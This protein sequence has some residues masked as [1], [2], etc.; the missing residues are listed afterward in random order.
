MPHTITLSNSGAVVPTTGAPDYGG[1][2]TDFALL[3]LALGTI[4]AALPGA[5]AVPV[6][7]ADTGAANAYAITYSPAPTVAAGSRFLFKALHTNTGAS[8]L[9]V[10][11]AATVPITDSVNAA[12]IG[13]EILAGQLCL[14]VYD[15]TQYQLIGSYNT[16]AIAAAI[17]NS[18]YEYAADTGAVN[19]YAVALTPSPAALV[20]GLS[21]QFKVKTLNTGASTLTVN[22]LAT[23]AI[24]KNG[25]TA[26]SGGELVA[27]AIVLVTYDGTQFQLI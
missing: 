6:Y 13:G 3:C 20:A 8:T 19:A 5:T 16:A 26:L 14:V 27:G 17:Q 10:N 24:T 11:G 2:A 4:D 7:A 12:L 23:K 21:F 22:S 18:S 9:A 25:A 1:G 15:G